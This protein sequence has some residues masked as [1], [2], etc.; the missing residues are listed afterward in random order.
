MET[1]QLNSR[2]ETNS[3]AGGKQLN[4]VSPAPRSNRRKQ[5][6]SAAGGNNSTPLQLET[7]KHT[8]RE[9]TQTSSRRKNNSTQQQDRKKKVTQLCTAFAAFTAESA[10]L[11]Y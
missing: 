8:R 4:S 9:T 11:I 3:A 10:F 6:N 1:T 2:L 7:Q 5:L